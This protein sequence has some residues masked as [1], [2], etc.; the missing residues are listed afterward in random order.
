MIQTNT[1][2]KHWTSLRVKLLH[3]QI[4][5]LVFLRGGEGETYVFKAS[6]AANKIAKQSSNRAN[7]HVR[8]EAEKVALRKMHRLTVAWK[9]ERKRSIMQTCPCNVEPHYTPL[10]YSKTGVYR[11]I[12]YFSCFCSENSLEREAVLTSTPDLCLRAIR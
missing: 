4:G 1:R 11:S 7:H 3:V 2:F 5:V 6:Q 12:D 9:K 8:S 10:L